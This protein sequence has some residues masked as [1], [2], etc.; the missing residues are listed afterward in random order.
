MTVNL[1]A[2]ASINIS[3]SFEGSNLSVEQEN[4][5]GVLS[6]DEQNYENLLWGTMVTNIITSFL[7]LLTAGIFI[8]NLLVIL[9]VATTSKLRRITD[10]YLLSLA[11]ADFLVSVFVLPF[12]IVR[13]HLGYWPFES[14]ILCYFY[15]SIDTQCCMAS[16]FNLCCISIDRFIAISYPIKYITK[17]NRATAL[18][19]IVIAWILPLPAIV[20]PLIGSY[21]HTSG[22]GNC[23]L[24][25]DKKYRI[26]S[27]VLGFFV[28]LLLLAFVNIRI[29]CIINNR[30]KAF[31]NVK[32][33]KLKHKT[34]KSDNA[35]MFSSSALCTPSY[36]TDF[37]RKW[38]KCRDS[39]T[40]FSNKDIGSSL[41]SLTSGCAG[42]HSQSLPGSIKKARSPID[43]QA[44]DKSHISAEA[45]SV[46][47]DRMYS[48][49]NLKERGTCSNQSSI[50]KIQ[51]FKGANS[52]IISPN[53]SS[54]NII[55]TSHN[56]YMS[57]TST[58][59]NAPEIPQSTN[60]LEFSTVKLHKLHQNLI[61]A[62][63]QVEKL[64]NISL[65]K[66]HARN[67][68][69]H[70]N[71]LVK[72][73]SPKSIQRH[74]RALLKK[75]KKTNRT[76]AAIVG[77]YTLCWLP[78]FTFFLGE[79][80]FDCTFSEGLYSFVCWLGYSNSI[81]NPLIYTFF[82]KEYACAFKR[83]LFIHKCS[84]LIRDGSF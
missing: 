1:L 55:Y 13:H 73:H 23:Y 72:K 76:V 26:Y 67:N 48:K 2:S 41:F 44:S 75:E 61:I 43:K 59:D 77:C 34:S 83:L 17:R 25:Y 36:R 5:T 33:H 27:S 31:E 38:N 62:N 12:A 24:S 66:D 39:Q 32:I 80:I 82:N 74:E 22:I 8:G 68:P 37:K 57:Q 9:A 15:I 60:K 49:D 65:S 29:F 30:M 54:D 42:K 3:S 53:L 4:K 47:D 11:I 10:Q 16:I 79:A 35:N 45:S 71:K 81:C 46:C 64:C 69:H 28:P 20:P 50:H 14:A 18:A 6:K 58:D 56:D 63:N 19:M 52:D 70:I 51:T 78:F 7:A 84:G 21:E 40:S